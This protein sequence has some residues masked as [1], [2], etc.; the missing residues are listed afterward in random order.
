VPEYAIF[1]K[2]TIER[3]YCYNIDLPIDMGTSTHRLTDRMMRKVAQSDALQAEINLSDLQQI[4]PD[5][6]GTETIILVQ[7]DGKRIWPNSH[8]KRVKKVLTPDLEDVAVED[9]MSSDTDS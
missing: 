3:V 1:T 4:G 8:A 7:R 9:A 5:D 2:Q 6:E